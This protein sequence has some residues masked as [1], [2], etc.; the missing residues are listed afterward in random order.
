[1][2]KV[3]AMEQR[4]A[5]ERF[6]ELFATTEDTFWNN[7]W[8]GVR[9]L[10]NPND[11]WVTQEIIQE[12]KPDFII[13]AGTFNG[14]SALLW[15]MVLKE[16]NPR[17]RVITIDIKDKVS[18]AR[19]R[20][21][22]KERIDFLVG[23]STDPEIVATVAERAKGKRVMVILDS[24]HSKEHVLRELESYAPLVS[25]G[26]YLIVQDTGGVMIRDP[27][28]G[29]RRAVEEFLAK[30]DRFEPDQS[31]ERMVFTLHPR[32]YLQR[33]R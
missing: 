20:T 26:S 27:N 8:L 2:V 30:Q 17:G 14:G 1:M 12:V 32:G 16:V 23:S 18:E 11:V 28:P 21:I 33:V 25:V 31:R 4:E 9:T 22:W 24:D 6:A 19:D 3:G 13:E 29:P 5:I 15:A 7:H 10:Q